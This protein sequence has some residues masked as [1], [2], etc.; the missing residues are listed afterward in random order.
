VKLSLSAISTLNAPFAEDVAA[1]AAAG[2]AAI[3]LWEMKLPPDDAANLELLRTHGLEV[4]NCVPTVPSFLALAIPGMEGP[5]DPPERV[6]AICASIRRLAA[7]DPECVLVLSGP[8]GGRSEAEGRAIVIDGLARAASAA[9]EVGVRLGLEPIHPAQRDSAGFGT[10]LADAL[11][12]LDEAG[13]DDVGIMADTFNLSREKTADVT[14]SARRFTGLHV[15]DEL[16]KPVAG[17]RALPGEGR[18]RSAELV[19]ALRNAGW[20]GTLDVEIFSTPDAFWRLPAE[21]AAR[22]AYASATALTELG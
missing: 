8:L 19:A 6:E 9:R 4:S 5:P 14:A 13:L 2:F 10:S 7:Y 22:R 12:L 20:A 3:G 16:P 1:Y 15:A 11:A 18:S 17:V 21:E